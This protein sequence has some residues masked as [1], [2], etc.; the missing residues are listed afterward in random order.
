M[1]T[2][3]I[4]NPL[5]VFSS[6]TA[7]RRLIEERRL[8]PFLLLHPKALP[9]FEGL[10][11]DSPNCGRRQGL[12]APLLS[13]GCCLIECLVKSDGLIAGQ[14]R[15]GCRCKHGLFAALPKTGRPMLARPALL[16]LHPSPCSCGGPGKGS[17]QLRQHES[18]VPNLAGR[19]RWGRACAWNE[20]PRF[21]CLLATPHVSAIMLRP[22]V[23]AVRCA[24][25]CPA[26]AL[27]STA[28]A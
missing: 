8:R 23:A 15:G 22:L 18:C 25:C 3:T 2:P 17:V 9:D 1:G 28:I 10:P 12:C 13:C 14:C 24:H 11:T 21:A 19:P 20:L 26:A 7:T 6:L 5:Q 4:T 27:R 16:P